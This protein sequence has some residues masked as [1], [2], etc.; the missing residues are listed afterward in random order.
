M[1]WYVMDKGIRRGAGGGGV[2]KMEVVDKRLLCSGLFV[3]WFSWGRACL[4]VGEGGDR[5]RRLLCLCWG[6][7]NGY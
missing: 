3:V 7:W 6:S 1:L 5:W 4:S 2:L